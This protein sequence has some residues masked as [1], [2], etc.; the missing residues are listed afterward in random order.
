MHT[1]LSPA[2]FM[3]ILDTILEMKCSSS[4]MMDANRPDT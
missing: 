1:A 4:V 3:T 2:K